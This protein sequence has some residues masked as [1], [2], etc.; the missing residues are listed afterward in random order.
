MVVLVV[1]VVAVVVVVIWHNAAG[2]R[3]QCYFAHESGGGS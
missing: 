2:V 1:V 3:E